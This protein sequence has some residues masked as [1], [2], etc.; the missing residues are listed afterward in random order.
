MRATKEKLNNPLP[1]RLRE[2]LNAAHH[3]LL[4]V[5]KSLLDHERVRYEQAHGKIGSSGELLQLVIG[6]P[7]FAWLR[8]ASGAIVQIDEFLESKTPADPREGEALLAQS[9]TLMIPSESG[10]E[11]QR[12]YFRSIQE[13]PEIAHLQ[14]EW[15]RALIEMDRKD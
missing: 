8:A 7:W 3:G 4:T 11:F 14:G 1:D 10:N 2:R 12:Q 15:K 5:H 9:R 13:S 6:D